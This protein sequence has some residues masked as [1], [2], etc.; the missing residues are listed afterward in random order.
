MER[1]PSVLIVDAGEETR[2]VLGTVLQRR[3]ME[4]FWAEAPEEALQLAQIHQ[5]DLIILDLQGEDGSVDRICQPLAQKVQQT[6]TPLVVLGT[7]RRQNRM[8]PG[9]VFP[10]P[11]HYGPLIRKIEQLIQGSSSA[12]KG[13]A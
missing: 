13:Q 8:I 5:P 1:K 12:K 6:Q 4:T 2:E 3:G 10:K 7:W 9:E 11:Y